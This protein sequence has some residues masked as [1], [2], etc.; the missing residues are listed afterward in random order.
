MKEKYSGMTVNERL[1]LS[2]LYDKFYN[3]V[4]EKDTQQVITILKSVEF[5]DDSTINPIL[6]QFGLKPK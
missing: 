3:A 5:S 4:K 2:G 1:Y 6:E